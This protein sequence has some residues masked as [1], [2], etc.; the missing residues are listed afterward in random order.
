MDDEYSDVDNNEEA[1]GTNFSRNIKD[2]WKKDVRPEFLNRT[3]DKK[4][5]K[6]GTS[7]KTG[8]GGAKETARNA[9]NNAAKGGFY[10]AN[11]SPRDSEKNP[12]GINYTGDGKAGV[13]KGAKKLKGSK[14]TA[15]IIVGIVALIVAAVVGFLGTPIFTIGAY[16]FNL[17]DS[18]G[19]LNRIGVLEAIASF[20]FGAELE[21]GVVSDQLAG[22]MAEHGLMV[23]QVT[24]S[25]DFVRTNTYVAN[26]D[27][28]KDLAVLGN[29]HA[30]PSNGQ[31]AVLFDNKVVEAK[32]FIATIESDPKMYMAVLEATDIGAAYWY[33]NDMEEQL[34]E[35][36]VDRLRS[37]FSDYVS[38]GDAEKDYE[39]YQKKKASALN[40]TSELSVVGISETSLVPDED[41]NYDESGVS[42]TSLSD[43]DDSNAILN[44][45]AD[46]ITGSDQNVATGKVAQSLNAVMSAGEPYLAAKCF[47]FGE[48]IVQRTRIQ[49]EAPIHEYMNDI[50]TR[51]SRP[52]VNA[53]NQEEVESDDSVLSS[54]TMGAT[55]GHGKFS[56][57]EAASL[58]RDSSVITM[59]SGGSIAT[60]ANMVLTSMV[61][62]DDIKNTVISTD[63]QKE[64]KVL[65]G[66]SG[67]EKASSDDLKI[68]GNRINRVMI[69]KNSDMF[70]G[71]DGGVR[72]PEG[73]EFIMNM[74]D[75]HLIGALAS[76]DE[77]V[78]EYHREAEKMV[79]RRAEAERATKSPF[80]VS[81]PY[82]FM[83]SL[84]RSISSIVM[85]SR[86]GSSGIGGSTI[87]LIANITGDSVK[88]LYD[89]AIADGDDGSY[90][91]A[92]GD[93]CETA[94]VAGASSSVL[95]GPKYTLV[96]KY[97]NT[98]SKELEDR[99]KKSGDLNEDGEIVE[100]SDLGEL[101]A[102]SGRRQST[103]GI[104]D[105]SVC[106]TYRQLHN[107]PL[108]EFIQG[109]AEI[110]G[111]YKACGGIAEVGI[112]SKYTL[113]SA[114]SNDED[115]EY[116]AT[117]VMYD[118]VKSLLDG[119]ESS[120]SR[121]RKRFDEKHP[122]DNSREGIIAR[123]SGLTKSEV[124]QAL[125]YA[126]YLVE[127][128]RYNPATRYTFG[129]VLTEKPEEPLVEHANKVSVDL[130]ALWHGRTEYDDLRGRIRVG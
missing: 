56:K 91:M 36:G 130:Y 41:G 122:L 33:S 1:G 20:V 77:K 51:V 8:D 127:I 121:F 74:V 62:E 58:S 90:E 60:N 95:C 19:F 37:L 112:G 86:V 111:Q 116:Y 81:S 65:M 18:I 3:D 129:G 5:E 17:L 12:G 102:I 15:G 38:T 6:T 26:A 14:K 34:K 72:I 89:T 24:A 70:L 125:A 25:G 29:Y 107:E 54:A 42:Q 75:S 106:E 85:K 83:G 119:T 21:D 108:D 123:R 49:G 69:E 99:L 113:G 84:T 68:L 11:A 44:D 78:A 118:R 31:L 52:Y 80:D 82:T 88:G 114:D 2:A 59:N 120:V 39:I 23:G 16:D 71:V 126:D 10:K 13:K 4:K 30:N 50:N 103:V 27:D 96:T 76:N 46:D 43:K 28:L 100:D 109:L 57:V 32:D 66:T 79:A 92:T 61:G 63:G 124:R 7:G 67:G 105:S 35:L 128:A 93:Y 117:Y 97:I 45:A 110:F 64:S 22:K 53:F 73:G 47:M 104:K 55:L 40:D 115:L 98:T 87:G 94:S 9:E 101:V 48:G